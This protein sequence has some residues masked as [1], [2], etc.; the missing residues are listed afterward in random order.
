MNEEYGSGLTVFLE[1]VNDII[2]LFAVIFI[3]VL[4]C[5]KK[6]SLKL[7]NPGVENG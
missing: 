1:F 4:F 6:N 7:K 5:V 3:V 2:F